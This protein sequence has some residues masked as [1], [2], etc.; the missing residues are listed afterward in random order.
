MHTSPA[1]RKVFEGIATRHEMYCM[2]KRH[3]GD[4]MWMSG[5]AGHVF[6]GEWFEIAE[7]EH[8]YML[9]ILPPLWM[10]ADMAAMRG[11]PDRQHH[12]RLLLTLDRWPQALLSRLLRSLRSRRA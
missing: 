11:V 2:F 4:P 1:P 6:A 9:E 7:R 10:R 12:E 5:D 3:R 8:D